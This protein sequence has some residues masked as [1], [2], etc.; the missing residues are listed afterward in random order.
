MATLHTQKAEGFT[1]TVEPKKETKKEHAERVKAQG[2]RD[3]IYT[4]GIDDG[5][6]TVQKHLQEKLE[7]L[8]G[9]LKSAQESGDMERV[10]T[11]Y[12]NFS[13]VRELEAFTAHQRFTNSQDLSDIL[14]DMDEVRK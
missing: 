9:F 12:A 5:L 13:L 4:R 3:I 1:A 8:R 11:C 14:R 10:T 2:L 7:S 6:H